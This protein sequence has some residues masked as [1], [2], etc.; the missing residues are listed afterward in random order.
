MAH[1]FV[2]VGWRNSCSTEIL[3]SWM[4]TSKNLQ[5]AQTNIF[6]KNLKWG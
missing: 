6:A 2:E 3:K 5:V 4:T 1:L